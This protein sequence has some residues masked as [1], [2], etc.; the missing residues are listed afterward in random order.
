MNSHDRPLLGDSERIWILTLLLGISWLGMA[1]PEHL[2]IV[3]GA[4]FA[5]AVL[6]LLP[7][8]EKWLRWNTGFV[9]GLLVFSGLAVGQ[10]VRTAFGTILGGWPSLQHDVMGI[11]TA[12]WAIVIGVLAVVA[13]CIIGGIQLFARPIHR[14]IE[15]PGPTPR[16]AA[17]GLIVPLTVCT[18][19][20]VV[21]RKANSSEI[22]LHVRTAIALLFLFHIYT[23]WPRRRW[24]SRW[25]L[26]GLFLLVIP[27][28]SERGWLPETEIP[29][30]LSAC[31]AVAGFFRILLD[32]GKVLVSLDDP[33]IRNFFFGGSWDR[34]AF[35]QIHD[36]LRGLMLFE[37]YGIQIMPIL[38]LALPPLGAL[39]IV[40]GEPRR[41]PMLYA[42][43]FLSF[44]ALTA[45]L[46]SPLHRVG[47]YW[48]V[49]LRELHVFWLTRAL[50]VQLVLAA[51]PLAATPLAK[52][53]A[54]REDPVGLP[55]S[56]RHPVPA[57]SRF[58]RLRK[59]PRFL[60]NERLL[61]PPLLLIL[62]L[63]GLVGG[64][65]TLVMYR[66]YGTFHGVIDPR[67][68]ETAQAPILKPLFT[69]RMSPAIPQGPRRPRTGMQNPPNRF[70]IEDYLLLNAPPKDLTAGGILP[71]EAA[72]DRLMHEAAR[73]E[74][75][76]YVVAFERAAEADVCGW[77]VLNQKNEVDSPHVI[78]VLYTARFI[79]A[80]AS[81]AMAQGRWEAARGDIR[82]VL[83]FAMVFGSEGTLHQRMIGLRIGE[84]DVRCAYAALLVSPDEEV[85]PLFEQLRSLHPWVRLLA[86]DAA[87]ES[88]EPRLG[89]PQRLVLSTIQLPIEL[90]ILRRDLSTTDLANVAQFRLVLLASATRYYYV[91]H[92]RLPAA[93][94][95]LRPLFGGPPP[96]DPFSGKDFV[97]TFS[98]NQVRFST[99][100]NAI[101]KSYDPTLFLLH[102]PATQ[103]LGITVKVDGQVSTTPPPP[104]E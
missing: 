72:C 2:G 9:A 87:F 82:R 48:P 85:S 81:V 33:L 63:S 91:E 42:F 80:R 53:L 67:P 24:I 38:A 29:L 76:E 36:L 17:C 65:C 46:W 61:L 15:L 75:H 96:L 30:L 97:A 58:G 68:G 55:G 4:T 35:L 74:I 62:A 83:R 59:V 45:A 21:T 103:R 16:Q 39:R 50:P 20:A 54:G 57:P 10:I 3:I 84:Q 28:G 40:R 13:M 41:R 92:G 69:S 27:R 89:W 64:M 34:N 78:N 25:L 101:P 31:G 98:A 90:P 95:D 32:L 102:V 93:S 19:L 1:L 71:T 23:Y 100:K 99:A 66:I 49:F 86:D 18:L 70:K 73:P 11:A 26:F 7:T 5:F 94:D 8:G 12:R 43:S 104:E 88:A 52:A 56:A 47:L 6:L 22:A 51:A 14:R 79:C 37:F 77:R 60:F 44:A